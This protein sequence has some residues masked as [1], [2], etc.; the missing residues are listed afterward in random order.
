[1]S[2]SRN[3]TD[4]F[5]QAHGPLPAEQAPPQVGGPVSTSEVGLQ[6][7]ADIQELN[8]HLLA[9]AR[10]QAVPPVRRAIDFD[11]TKLTH[12][13]DVGDGRAA[14]GFG[15]YNPY[16]CKTYVGIGGATP[17]AGSGAIEVPGKAFLVMP[18]FVQD[19]EIAADLTDLTTLGTSITVHFL[20]FE[21]VPAPFLYT[22]A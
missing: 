13:D 15:I 20:R 10:R 3:P 11:L 9:H 22:L 19:V 6:A 21:Q 14:L 17:R 18:L 1:M 8:H 12:R 2:N 16:A 4:P 7:L 5:T